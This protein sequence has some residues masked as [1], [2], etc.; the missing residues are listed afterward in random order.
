MTLSSE[1][2]NYWINSGVNPGDNILFHSDIK[3]TFLYFKRK[4]RNFIL[5]NYFDSLLEVV[6]PDGTIAFPTF[7]FDFNKGVDFD[8]L[9]TP[10]KMGSLSEFSR[11]NKMSY[12]TL[13]PIYSFSIIGRLQNKFKD[14]ESISWYS[15]E[16]TFHLFK[17][18]NFKILI[19]DLDDNNSMTFLHYCEESFQ[20]NYR[21]YKNFSGYYIDHEQNK[22]FKKYKGFVRNLEQNIQTSCNNAAEI[23]WNKKIYKGNKP[24]IGNGI[25]YI[26]A[27]EYFNFFK[28]CYEKNNL[29]NVFYTGNI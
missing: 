22:L 17:E 23:L 5:E 14:I 20:V 15:K 28:E 25:R 8:Y 24:F 7:N 19:L 11:Q 29:R 4:Y 10:S 3:K 27:N 1:L 16:S 13:D 26:Y 6:L 9:K 12:R 2:K 21:Y 18:F